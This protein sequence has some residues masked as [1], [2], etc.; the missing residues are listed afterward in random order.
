MALL[1][2]LS[3]C[4]S[5]GS[6]GSAERLGTPVATVPHGN[7][8]TPSSGSGAEPTVPTDGPEGATAAIVVRSYQDWWGAQADAFG[9]SDSDSSQLQLYS[10]GQ[11]LSDSVASLHQLHEAKLVMSGAPR[12]APIVKALDLTA[13]PQT[14]VIE[15]CLDVTDW[16]Q[17]DAVTKAT[18]DPKQRLSRYVATVGLRKAAGRWLIVDFKREVGRTC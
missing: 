15:D 11:A 4:G 14:A 10:T 18:K 1:L 3:A 16:H 5:S 13:E 12:N 9:K 6:A 17:A 2:V 7:G 8:V